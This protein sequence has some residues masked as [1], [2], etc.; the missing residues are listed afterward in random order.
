MVNA[1]NESEVL[2]CGDHEEDMV[3][4]AEF[5]TFQL[6]KNQQGD[7]PTGR[8]P[9]QERAKVFHER[10]PEIPCRQL[11]Y[12]DNLSED[13]EDA[14]AII[15]NNWKGYQGEQDRQTFRMKMDLP[16]FN[17]Q[18]QIEGFLDWL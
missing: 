4:G 1:R 15:R 12:E 17:G 3:T 6:G 14:E 11:A 2:D 18:L 9:Y 13:E 10:H 16:S 7:D 8:Q 5:R